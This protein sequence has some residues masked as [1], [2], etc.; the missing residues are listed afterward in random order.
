MLLFTKQTDA[1]NAAEISGELSKASV[2]PSA[3]RGA[4][5]RFQ[6]KAGHSLPGE[7]GHRSEPQKGAKGTHSKHPK[8]LLKSLC[9]STLLTE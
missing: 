2:R 7:P 9:K 6:A 4:G 5:T 8:E 3:R 1:G